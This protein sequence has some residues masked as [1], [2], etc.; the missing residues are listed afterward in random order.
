MTSADRYRK[1]ASHL[2]AK[3]RN[4]QSPKLRAEWYHLA[5]SY[6][7]LAAQAERNARADVTYKHALRLR[8]DD[9]GGKLA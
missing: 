7:R 5:Q 6:L 1:L 8:L 3:A 2:T 9:L 4:E